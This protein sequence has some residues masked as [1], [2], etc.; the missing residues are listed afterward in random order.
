MMLDA[1]VAVGA[2]SARTLE[3]AIGRPHGSIRTI[4]N[5]VA[6]GRW[7][8]RRVA[9]PPSIVTL[10]RLDPVK[11]LDVLV[12]ALVA[13]PAV[14]AVDRRRRTGTRRARPAGRGARRR[15]PPAPAGLGS[16]RRGICSAGAS[17]SCCPSREEGLP[18]SIAEAML[19]GRAVV[20]S[21]VGS[22]REIVEDGVTGL[23]VPPDDADA[24]AR[25]IASAARRRRPAA[26]RWDARG[27][28]RAVAQF[29]APRMAGE[30]ER[31]YGELTGWRPARSST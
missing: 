27:R 4:R 20:A 18:L 17:C 29:T 19:A 31:L 24:L 16:R 28:D 10:A 15:R 9:G 7:A 30:F 25:A 12:E 13:L 2:A 26:P 6:D 23:L 21:D 8:C 22:V 14:H 1:H 11:G 5:A 3:A